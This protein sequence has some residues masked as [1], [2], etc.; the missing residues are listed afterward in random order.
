MSKRNLFNPS[1]KEKPDDKTLFIKKLNEF[2]QD[3]KNK[4]R[5][6]KIIDT[7]ITPQ[8]VGVKIQGNMCYIYYSSDVSLTQLKLKGDIRVK[9]I[10]GISD[11]L[12]NKKYDITTTSIIIFKAQYKIENL[13]NNTIKEGYSYRF[14][15]PVWRYDISDFDKESLSYEMIYDIN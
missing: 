6:K 14:F 7:L 5:V 15:L 3:M 12:I 9:D 8:T 2:L 13:Q 10:S 11:N 1:I 4:N